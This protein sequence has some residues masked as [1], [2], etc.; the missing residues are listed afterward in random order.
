MRFIVLAAAL[1][2]LFTATAHAEG[3]GALEGHTLTEETRA[4]QTLEI[5][6]QAE[7]ELTHR[8][9]ATVKGVV[10][11]VDPDG[12]IIVIATPTGDMPFVFDEN[13]R[14]QVKLRFV[15][16]SDVEAGTRV[17]GLFSNRGGTIYLERLMLIPEAAYGPTKPGDMKHKKASR[18]SRHSKRHSKKAGKAGKSKSSKTTKSTKTKKKHTHR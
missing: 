14:F 16:L 7:M 12:R 8:T 3:P 9:V 18:S 13:T 15:K 2:A 5:I 11:S 1:L 4:S 10:S 6:R 17:A